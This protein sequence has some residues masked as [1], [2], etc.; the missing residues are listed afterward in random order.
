VVNG[1]ID[2]SARGDAA[3][4]VMGG[5]VGGILHPNPKTALVIGLGTG[6]TA[7]WLGSVAGIERVD[8]VEFEPVIRSV[9]G[10]CV[11]VNRNVL[12]NPR[13]AITI[14]DAREFLLT[15]KQSYDIVSRPPTLIAPESPALARGMRAAL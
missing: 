6:S 14:G 8:V 15:T 2:G 12:E 13:V 7:G 11:S 3:T 5:L 9:A 4:Q 10:A 1:K